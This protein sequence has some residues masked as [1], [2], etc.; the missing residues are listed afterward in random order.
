MAGTDFTRMTLSLL[1][2]SSRTDEQTDK[3]EEIDRSKK[4]SDQ[5]GI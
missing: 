5:R 2:H 4:G 3:Q 1:L